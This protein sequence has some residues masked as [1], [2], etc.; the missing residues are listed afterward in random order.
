MKFN[1]KGRK[2]QSKTPNLLP[3]KIFHFW[4]LLLSNSFSMALQVPQ[5]S[6]MEIK[7]ISIRFWAEIRHK[8]YVFAMIL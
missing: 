7:T 4:S 2:I 1:I 8:R 5:Y 6:L 3:L